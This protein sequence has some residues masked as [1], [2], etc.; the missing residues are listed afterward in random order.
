[1]H[2]YYLV[3]FLACSFLVCSSRAQQSW[4]EDQYPDKWNDLAR[5]SL[6]SLLNK[7]TNKNVAK[8]IILYLGDGM[9]MST[10]NY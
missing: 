3:A 7:K 10:G 2:F 5:N 1:M 9:G 6:N 4:L 8:N